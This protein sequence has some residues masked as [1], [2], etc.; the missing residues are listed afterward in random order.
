[1]TQAHTLLHGDESAALG[2]AGYQ[3]MEKQPENSGKSVTWHV[4]MKR[5]KR[6]ALPNNKL[7][8][9]PLHA[10]SRAHAY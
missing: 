6:K 8:R 3:G 4:S 9:L 1:M 5:S 2:D 10:A 7:G